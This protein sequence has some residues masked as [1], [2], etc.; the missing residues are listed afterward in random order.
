MFSKVKEF[1]IYSGILLGLM[2]FGWTICV[3]GLSVL[4]VL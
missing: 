2:A 3:V 4:E 1:G